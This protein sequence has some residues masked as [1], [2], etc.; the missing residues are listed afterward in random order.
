MLYLL[1]T[2][3]GNLE[4]VS[5]RALKILKEA[6]LIL[7]EDTRKAGLL[8]KNLNLPKKNFLSFY[9]YNEERRIPQVVK[10]LKEEKKVVLLS[11]AGT[12]LVSDPG[13]K[14]VKKCIEENLSFTSIPGPSAPINA[15]V[16]SGL[17]S[18]NFLFLGFLPRKKGKRLKKISQI[19]D[20]PYTLILFE[21]PQRI[22]K[23]LKELKE[24]LGERKVCLCREM[25]KVYEETLRGDLTTLINILSKRS[26]RGE[27]TLVLEGKI[28]RHF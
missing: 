21:S 14:L 16:L 28:Q 10:I 27:I 8:L 13:F 26:L 22:L 24:I 9:E 11:R 1:A 3:L 19:K 15:L 25:T 18:D 17:P 6:D 5:L 12:P 2:P 7:A 4:D 23:T 20:L